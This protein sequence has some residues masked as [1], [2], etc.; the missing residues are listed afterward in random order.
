MSQNKQDRKTIIQN[1]ILAGARK[2]L[3]GFIWMMKILVP[4]SFFTALLVWSGWLER[5]QFLIEPVMK[6]LNLPAAAALPLLIGTMTTIYGAIGAMAVLPLSREQMTLIAVFLVIAH[7]LIQESAIQGKSGLNPFKAALYRLITATITILL[8]AP[9]LDLSA[10]VHVEPVGFGKA[11]QPFGMMLLNWLQ[12]T[13][14]LAVRLLVIITSVLTFLEVSKALGWIERVVGFC[15]PVF[16]IMGLSEK[17]GIL[18]IA[19]AGFGLFFGGAVIVEETK[20]RIFDKQELERLHLSIGI[21]H[22][23]FEDPA[24][25]LTLGLNPFWLWIPRIVMAIIAVR[26]FILWQHI[27]KRYIVS[28]TRL[29]ER[30]GGPSSW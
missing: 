8:I 6:W 10:S 28:S 26:I 5:G 25:F 7:C 29:N 12:I 4:I 17:T 22:A 21:N 11:Y 3:S 13:T 16:R 14:S 27:K 18:W 1:S 9:F 24:L 20:G 2:G 23:V 15:R 19:A 30:T